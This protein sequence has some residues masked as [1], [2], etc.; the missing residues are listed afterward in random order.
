MTGLS[1]HRPSQESPMPIVADPP[2]ANT[3]RARFR[4]PPWHDNHPSKLDLEQ[5]LDP[6]H[7][8]R[9]YDHAV[10]RLDLRALR[11]SYGATGAQAHPPERLLR[12]VLLELR[13]GHHRPAQWH[14]NAQE[15]EP[16][17]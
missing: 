13:R 4:T 17:R 5:R 2:P 1:K 6:D 8:A 16:I 12:V 15:C 14:R 7:L 3:A 11:A 10:E 9:L